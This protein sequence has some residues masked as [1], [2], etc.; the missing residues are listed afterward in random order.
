MIVEKSDGSRLQIACTVYN[1]WSRCRD[2]PLNQTFQA[3]KT[4]RGLTIRY[5][6]RHGKMRKQIYEIVSKGH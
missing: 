3:M 5:R 2:L 6:D 1:E 4:K